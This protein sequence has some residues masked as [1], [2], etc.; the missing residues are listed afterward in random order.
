[1]VEF[2]VVKCILYEEARFFLSNCP[3][4][5]MDGNN[6]GEPCECSIGDAKKKRHLG[7][8]LLSK[9]LFFTEFHKS[10]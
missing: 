2:I 7:A 1:M 9:F 5:Q 6:D 3:G 4:T 8:F 10:F